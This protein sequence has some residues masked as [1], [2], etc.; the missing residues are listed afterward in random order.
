MSASFAPSL[1]HMIL[2]KIA[3][4]ICNDSE[5]RCFVNELDFLWDKIAGEDRWKDLLGKAAEKIS[6]L[7]LP[8]QLHLS[9]LGVIKP[10]ALEVAKWKIDHLKVLG[11][12][13]DFLTCELYWKPEG[14][15]DREKTAKML[16]LNKNLCDVNRFF[17][18][19]CYCLEN[20]VQNIW[21]FMTH[22]EE[23]RAYNSNF[24]CVT[25]W[26]SWIDRKG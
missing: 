24:F 2:A 16:V 11:D 1:K 19:C 15:I 21:K 23:C 12:K 4:Q 7:N 17:L 13:F 25:F 22:T 26:C 18:A 20:E 5:V 3:I 10:I 14:I 6:E 8:H 9:V